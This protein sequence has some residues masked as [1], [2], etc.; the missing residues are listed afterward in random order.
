M[1]HLKEDLDVVDRI[2]SFSAPS[3]QA[4]LSTAALELINQTSFPRN[5]PSRPMGSL[6]G[7]CSSLHQ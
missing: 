7:G 5:C 3:P 1:V 4:L 2:Q 6:L